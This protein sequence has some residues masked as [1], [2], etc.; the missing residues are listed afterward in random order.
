VVY[1]C[2]D[3]VFFMFLTALHM[4]GLFQ[5]TELE[6]LI[7]YHHNQYQKI[8]Y[9]SVPMWTN[10]IHTYIYIYIYISKFT[11]IYFCKYRMYI[12]SYRSS[13]ANHN[14]GCRARTCRG[15]GIFTG[16]WMCVETGC[17]L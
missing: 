10:H 2:G 6:C 11:N 9:I 14:G 7:M 8:L 17:M 1:I 16:M 15:W 5:H 13:G 12:W 4:E 3:V